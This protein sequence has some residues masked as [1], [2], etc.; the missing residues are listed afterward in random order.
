MKKI[1]RILYFTLLFVLLLGFGSCSSD[2]KITEEPPAVSLTEKAQGFLNGEFAMRA[3]ATMSG[4]SK[5]L[6]PEGCP[7][8][9]EFEWKSDNV[10]NVTISE[11]TVG[12][13]PLVITYTCNTD[14][15][16]LN[17]W[18][19]DEYPG[20]GWIKFKGTDGYTVMDNGGEVQED[21]IRGSFLQGYYNVDT[22]QITFIIDYNAMNVRSEVYLQIAD[23]SKM[24]TYEE[25]FAQYEKDLAAY[26][27]EHGL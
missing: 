21:P 4:V 14:I 24:D 11:F 20:N 7:A 26:K 10:L 15:M 8:I 18:E 5:T 27:K 16:Q 2:D 9:F 6:L 23:K 3:H 19:K 1:N 13:M 17:S 25:D 12:N 22:H